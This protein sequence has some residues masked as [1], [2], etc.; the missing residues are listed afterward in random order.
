MPT[1]GRDIHIGD[2][3]NRFQLATA[4][5]WKHISHMDDQI[6]MDFQAVIYLMKI[7]QKPDLWLNWFY[8]QSQRYNSTEKQTR[9]HMNS[10]GNIDFII[11]YRLAK[12]SRSGGVEC[13]LYLNG[14]KQNA[15]QWDTDTHNHNNQHRLQW[16]IWTDKENNRNWSTLPDLELCKCSFL[17]PEAISLI[18][19]YWNHNNKNL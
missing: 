7:L 8:T 9:Y 19:R 1:K 18:I 13:F 14:K 12:L 5:W 11:S 16:D 10:H 17:F 6:T 3:R 4:I 2:W 15:N